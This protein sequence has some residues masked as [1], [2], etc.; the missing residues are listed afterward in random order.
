MNTQAIHL[1]ISFALTGLVITSVM[2]LKSTGIMEEKLYTALAVINAL[3]LC[4]MM[5]N[6]KSNASCAD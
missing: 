2:A 4:R 1:K 5:G 3:L 6:N